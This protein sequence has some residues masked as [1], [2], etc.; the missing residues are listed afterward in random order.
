MYVLLA[1]GTVV[2]LAVLTVLWPGLATEEAW[3]HAVVVLVLTILLFARAR[4]RGGG[5]SPRCAR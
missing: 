3:S 2:L 4:W 5:A 1:V